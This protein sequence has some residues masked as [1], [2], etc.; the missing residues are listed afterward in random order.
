MFAF[1]SPFWPLLI[2]GQHSI[3]LFLIV[4][5]FA[6][7]LSN[8]ASQHPRARGIP[9]AYVTMRP[10]SQSRNKW[11]E[12]GRRFERWIFYNHRKATRTIIST[13]GACVVLRN[14]FSSRWATVSLQLYGA[15]KC[16]FTMK[17]A[18]F[19][20]M[21]KCSPYM[22]RCLG[23][24]TCSRWFLARLIFDPEDGGDTFPQNVDWLSMDYIALHPGRQYSS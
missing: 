2:D 11:S 5:Y 18:I 19:L 7:V 1:D 12:M 22:S 17:L 4:R 9:Q 13:V 10:R 24:C 14:M 20:N 16:L 3:T 21:T 23:R 8:V 15:H 6:A